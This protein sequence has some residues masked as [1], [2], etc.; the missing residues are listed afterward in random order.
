MEMFLLILLALV[1]HFGVPVVIG[2]AVACYLIEAG[3]AKLQLR[4]LVCATDADCPPG[5]IYV[6]GRC[7]PT[8][9]KN[10]AGISIK[11]RLAD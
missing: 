9:A 2:L 4:E 7:V 1:I 5:H 3:W 11:T 6:G 8:Y 10:G